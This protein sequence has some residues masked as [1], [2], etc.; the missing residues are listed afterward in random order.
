M[1]Q[2]H[3]VIAIHAGRLRTGHRARGRRRSAASALPRNAGGKDRYSGSALASPPPHGWA[4]AQDDGHPRLSARAATRRAEIIPA[5]SQ[6]ISSG[7]LAADARDDESQEYELNAS[8]DHPLDRQLVRH[9]VYDIFA[10][11]GGNHREEGDQ[12]AVANALRQPGF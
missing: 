8:C 5:W 6:T 12:D 9:D 11:R 3:Q 2:D 1:E 10:Q 4:D 7:R